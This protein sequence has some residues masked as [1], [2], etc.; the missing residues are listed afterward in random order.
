MLAR[1][2]MKLEKADGI[3]YQMSSAF[4]GALME[5]FPKEYGEKLHLS[6]L[7][8]YTQHLEFREGDWYWIVIAL[9]EETAD[10]IIGKVLMPLSEITIKK[11][12][13]CLKIQDKMYK[14]LSDR[15]LA[16]SFYQEQSSPF[17]SI[18]FIT[19]TTFKQNGKYLNYP[20]I[21]CI[22]TNL[23]NKYD[24]SNTEESMKD[25]ETLEQ[26]VESTSIFRYDLKSIWFSLESVKI[27]AFIGKVTFRLR[28]SQTMINFANLLFRFSTY[29]GIGVKT[30]LGMGAVRIM[31]ERKKQNG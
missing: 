29:S 20:D 8:P 10:Q 1:L 5:L 12:H 3:S 17:I 25:E 28:G 30:A 11:H 7:H 22:Y 6:K 21:R 15:E 2:E 19:P 16:F 23:M 26:L 4:H 27:P 14:E 13:L 31:E 9:N 24:A 18:H